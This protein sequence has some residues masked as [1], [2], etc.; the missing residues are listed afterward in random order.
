MIQI[1]LS[2]S[3]ELG[4]SVF[5]TIESCIRDVFSRLISNK[6]SVNSNKTDHLQFNPNN[7][8]LLVIIINLGYNTISPSDNAKALG[9]IFQPIM[10]MDKHV[11]SIIKSCFLQL[12]DFRRTCPMICYKLFYKFQSVV[13]A[14]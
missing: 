13:Y 10:S 14:V 9:V 5:S 6:L 3:P 1:Y 2:F 7:V 4:L 11:S 12:R 8:N